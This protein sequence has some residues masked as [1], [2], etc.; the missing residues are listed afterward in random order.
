MH[1]KAAGVLFHLTTTLLLTGLAHEPLTQNA[2]LKIL[3]MRLDLERNCMTE[4]LGLAYELLTQNLT[5]G[6]WSGC[7]PR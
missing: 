7:M 5:A 2:M 3:K 6:G 1:D 4:T